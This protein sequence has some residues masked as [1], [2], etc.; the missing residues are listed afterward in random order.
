MSLS[1]ILT[2]LGAAIEALPSSP[3]ALSEEYRRTHRIAPAAVNYQVQLSQIAELEGGSSEVKR[4][5]GR[6]VVRIWARP[7]SMALYTRVTMIADQ[8]KLYSP[9]WWRED[10]TAGTGITGI[11]N[12]TEPREEEE[13]TLFG[14]VLVYAVRVEAHVNL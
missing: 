3:T 10:S 4:A 11:Y 9:A 14:P 12:V 13:P 6:V 5:V 1:S 2:P 7:A 8:E